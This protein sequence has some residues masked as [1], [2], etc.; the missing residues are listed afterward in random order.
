MNG[1]CSALAL[2]LLLPSTN[3]LA[4]EVD[5]RSVD[6][7]SAEVGE[8]LADLDPAQAAAKKLELA[9]AAS[10]RPKWVDKGSWTEGGVAFAAAGASGIKNPTMFV[11]T[12]ENRARAGLGTTKVEATEVKDASGKVVGRSVTTKGVGA[13]GGESVTLDWYWDPKTETLFT[14]VAKRG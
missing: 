6:A 2:T 13:P 8:L 7:R 11:R 4:W 10:A 1:Y 14:L 12:S 9:K 5:P 3:A